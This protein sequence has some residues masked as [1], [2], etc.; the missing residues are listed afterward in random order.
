MLGQL[1]KMTYLVAFLANFYKNDV[2]CR[3]LGQLIN[4]S[5][6]VTCLAN[7]RKQRPIYSINNVITSK[8]KK[9]KKLNG[10]NSG[11][12]TYFVLLVHYMLYR[13]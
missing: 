2:P 10:V 9:C 7:L 4:M 6:L 12:W 8:K 3:M 13:C 5:Y 11:T 1:I